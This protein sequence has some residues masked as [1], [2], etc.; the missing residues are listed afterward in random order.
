LAINLW[1]KVVADIIDISA[2]RKSFPKG[3]QRFESWLRELGADD[4]LISFSCRRYDEL[5]QE[6]GSLGQYSFSVS[7]ASP[8]SQE[9]QNEMYRQVQEGIAQVQNKFR[10]KNSQLA[11]RLLLAEIK[12]YQYERE[13]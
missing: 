7:L 1:R 9:D 5:I 12:V 2:Y 4:D 11:A 13:R 8:L 3:K 10:S 6:Q